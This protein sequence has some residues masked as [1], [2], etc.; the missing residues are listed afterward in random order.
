MSND[1]EAIAEKALKNPA[2]TEE[3]ME[4]QTFMKKVEE[5]TIFQLEKRLVQSKNRLVFLVDCA[6]F[7][8]AEIRL[9]SST[10]TWHGRMP[11]VFEEYKNVFKEKKNQ[12]EEGL[13]VCIMGLCG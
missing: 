11:A 4:L 8:P 5:E 7:S 1:Y 2:N 13:K 9:N 12:Y 3:L 6:N 10:F